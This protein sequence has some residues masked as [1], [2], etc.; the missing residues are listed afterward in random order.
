MQTEHKTNLQFLTGLIEDGLVQG[1][2]SNQVV[3]LQNRVPGVECLGLRGALGAYGEAG[4]LAKGGG[5]W[6]AEEVAVEID[7]GGERGRELEE[8]RE[9]EEG[10]AATV[11]IG[12][13]ALDRTI[14]GD[15]SVAQLHGLYHELS[16]R[17][18]ECRLIGW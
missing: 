8:R 7:G 17:G 10:D 1:P 13:H 12:H 18:F 2:N 4:V 3:G 11:V 14:V 16:S 15:S 9:S 6:D 5:E